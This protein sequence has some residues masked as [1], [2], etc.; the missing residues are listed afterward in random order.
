MCSLPLLTVQ[1]GSEAESRFESQAHTDR[2]VRILTRSVTGV[3]WTTVY[4]DAIL[5]N[6]KVPRGTGNALHATDGGL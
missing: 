2:A 1:R 4:S 5:G 3:T 6:T